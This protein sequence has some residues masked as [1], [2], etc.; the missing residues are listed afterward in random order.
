MTCA[1]VDHAGLRGVADDALRGLEVRH[2]HLGLHDACSAR[3]TAR[4][5]APTSG[6]GRWPAAPDRSPRP[7]VSPRTN[8]RATISIDAP[9][10]GRLS[11]RAPG[12]GAGR[13]GAAGWRGSRRD[14]AT[15]PG[16]PIRQAAP[17]V[18]LGPDHG[19]QARDS[20][21]VGSRRSRTPT[22]C[23]SHGRRGCGGRRPRTRR[24]APEGR[25][26]RRW[27]TRRRSAWSGGP[28]PSGS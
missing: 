16:P 8:T 27:R 6:L 10:P 19:A 18:G 28:R 15:V 2:L 26:S 11:A 13:D 9:P 12:R 3:G 23:A 17:S 21:S 5:G 20:P 14:D 25:R 1:R 7:G 22:P 24:E 4:A